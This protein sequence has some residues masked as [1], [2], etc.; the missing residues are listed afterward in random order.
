MKKL[1]ETFPRIAA[2]DA[3]IS[4]SKGSGEQSLRNQLQARYDETVLRFLLAVP[5]G[6]DELAVGWTIKAGRLRL[7]LDRRPSA[8]AKRQPLRLSAK[9]LRET[10]HLQETKGL[11][12]VDAGALPC[13]RAFAADPVNAVALRLLQLRLKSDVRQ[14]PLDAGARSGPAHAAELSHQHPAAA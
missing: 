5:V 13:L 3:R 6:D 7:A 9:P 12:W 4:T 14:A 11:R 1:T 8:A 2:N 10:Y